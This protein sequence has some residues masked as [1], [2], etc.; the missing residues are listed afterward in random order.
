MKDMTRYAVWASGLVGVLFVPSV[1]FA[2][3]ANLRCKADADTC[4]IIDNLVN[5]ILYPILELLLAA[6]VLVFVFGV[7]EYLW[8]LREGKP[9]KEGQDHMLYGLAG[10]FV[11]TTSIAILNAIAGTVR[12]LFP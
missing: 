2:Q 9:V 6:S 5:V 10:L 1:A 7:V 11:I 8:K 3:F 12:A 4:R